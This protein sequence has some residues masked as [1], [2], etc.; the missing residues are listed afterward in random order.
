MSVDRRQA[1][2]F[3]M[4][5]PVIFS[6]TDDQGN[7]HEGAGF[8]RNISTAGLLVIVHSAP[9]SQLALVDVEVILPAIGE[10]VRGLQLKSQGPVVRLEGLPDGMG[11]G[12]ASPFAVVETGEG[13][14]VMAAKRS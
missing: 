3:E 14:G 8:T 13:P 1:R 10:G 7:R 11:V 2:R 12:I 6:W 9:P 5:A 4:C